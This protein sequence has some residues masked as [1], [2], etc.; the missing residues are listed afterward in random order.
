MTKHSD[1]K[2]WSFGLVALI[3]LGG[4][5]LWNLSGGELTD[6]AQLQ[7]HYSTQLLNGE[8]FRLNPHDP[9]T[10][11]AA[12]PLLVAALSLGRWVFGADNGILIARIIGIGLLIGYALFAFWY[13][14][15]LGA[16]PPRAGFVA[17][18]P[19]LT[20]LI[21]S[22][23]GGAHPAAFDGLLLLVVVYG[24][25]RSFPV[26]VAA[27]VTLMFTSYAGMFAGLLLCAVVPTMEVIKHIPLKKRDLW[28]LLPFALGV[29]RAILSHSLWD[30]PPLAAVL[31]P[32]ATTSG[33]SVM[34]R[35]ALILRLPFDVFAGIGGSAWGMLPALAAFGL[36]IHHFNWRLA[37]ATGLLGVM[38][39]ALVMR[40]NEL[41][42]FWLI[43]LVVVII[44]VVL[45][46]EFSQKHKLVLTVVVG[47]LILLPA[48]IPFEDNGEE[49]FQPEYDELLPERS[50]VATTLPGHYLNLTSLR[51]AD[52]SGTTPPDLSETPSQYTLQLEHWA[53]E[54]KTRRPVY[55]LGTVE[56]CQLTREVIPGLRAI[57]WTP[58]ERRSGL[59]EPETLEQLQNRLLIERIDVGADPA[60]LKRFSVESY[61]TSH[62]SWELLVHNQLIRG[63]ETPVA[64]T[65]LVYEDT[66]ALRLDVSLVRGTQLVC[67]RVAVENARELEVRGEADSDSLFFQLEEDCWN[68]LVFP[69]SSDA[70]L[71]RLTIKGLG[72]D[73]RFFLG[74]IWLFH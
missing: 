10:D 58:L 71:A 48:L 45:G 42:V 6:A 63:R 20:P 55:L 54:T 52:L 33:A 25:L 12:N 1:R 49:R 73:A 23:A 17:I 16:D 22:G 4:G 5:V 40:G 65:C 35:L 3:A 50:F 31:S 53:M 2:L 44:P 8:S 11:A 28:L 74:T 32:L 18:L 26:L 56:N 34:A 64:D 67:L 62:S 21:L 47:L 38:L 68:E 9:T 59:W 37:T 30:S 46:R 43:P 39:T 61:G 15:H 72:E 13:A 41:I 29:I 51:V 70:A 27:L 19:I 69:V 66:P 7:L 60:A 36:I 14:R 57:V 24:I